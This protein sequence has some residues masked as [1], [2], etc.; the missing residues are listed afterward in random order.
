MRERLT[1]DRLVRPL[2]GARQGSD[3]ALED[4]LCL[5]RP[6]LLD[7]A[8]RHAKEDPEPEELA[9]DLT[10]D[11]LIR[12]ARNIESC[13]ADDDAQVLAWALSIMRNLCMDHFRRART[14][15]YTLRLSFAAADGWD[16]ALAARNSGRDGHPRR[17]RARRTLNTLVRRVIDH[18]PAA[19]ARLIRMRVRE[20]RSWREIGEALGTSEE[21]ARKRFKRLRSSLKRELLLRID[22]LSAAERAAV[23]RHLRR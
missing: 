10:Q 1:K 9:R 11:A 7:Y 19:A 2:F 23:L 12:I 15:G 5:L 4:L 16:V 14:R 21:G 17:R 18:L 6:G 13:R 20:E 3:D 8:R 22:E